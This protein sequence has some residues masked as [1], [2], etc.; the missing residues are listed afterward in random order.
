MQKTKPHGISPF[1]NKMA[2]LVSRQTK[3][4]PHHL[5][6]SVVAQQMADSGIN[7]MVV[8]QNGV[9]AG[10]VTSTDLVRHILA[11]NLSGSTPIFS[12]MS[13][14]LISIDQESPIFDGLMLMVQNKI[15]H[16]A[17]TTNGNISGI[18]SGWDWLTFQE[19][20]PAALFNEIAEAPSFQTVALLRTEALELVEQ[21]FE[22]E[23]NAR[24]LTQLI[25]EINDRV[26]ERIIQLTLEKLKAEG[27]GNPPVKYCWIAMGSEG[28]KEQTLSTDQ[29]NGLVFENTSQAEL[30]SV[31][32]WFLKFAVIVIEGLVLCGFPRC[33]GNIMASNQDLCLSQTEWEQL[34]VKIL[35]NPDPYALLKASI[36]FDFRSIYGESKLV[37]SLWQ[38]LTDKIRLSRGFLRHLAQNNIEAGRPPIYTLEWKFRSFFSLFL[39]PVDLKRQALTPLVMSIRTLALAHGIKETHTLSRIEE[40]V[41]CQ[42]L[43]AQLAEA[44]SNAYDFIMLLKI[45]QNFEFQADSSAVTN[46][47][48]TKLLNPL[49]SSF[50]YE[51]LKTIYDLQDYVNDIFGN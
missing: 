38:N 35:S 24:S 4:I 39:P 13:A 10:I 8:E 41:A 29:D 32:N 50:L 26:T 47:L 6:V 36:Y 17:V 34:F 51:T 2:D 27:E 49:Q 31:K 19:R 33:K 30:D 12:V 46:E 45:R 16:L 23:G 42:A 9:L 28:R 40:L 1:K 37:N 3:S 14:P 25:T 22:E 11:K 15:K 48:Q 20:H 7:S 44:V 18:V 43:P 5:P 21:L